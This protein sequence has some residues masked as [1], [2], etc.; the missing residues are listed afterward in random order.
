[1]PSRTEGFPLALFEAMASGLPVVVSDIPAF[2]ELLG[3]ECN[4]VSLSDPT[5]LRSIIKKYL[6]DPNLL[7]KDGEKMRELAKVKA[8][9]EVYL[10][11]IVDL[12]R[13][14]TDGTVIL[15]A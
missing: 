15:N 11:K 2:H 9:K 1:M 3:E 6:S 7:K 8:N 14:V 5:S 12:Y 10:E 4:F 13:Q